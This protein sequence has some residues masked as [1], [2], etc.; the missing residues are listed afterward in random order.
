[1]AGVNSESK[2]PYVSAV[3][4]EQAAATRARVAAAAGRCFAESGWSGT[5]LAQIARQAGV[6]PQ[7]VHL[8]IGPKPALLKAALV[9]AVG[10]GEADDPELEQEV[11]RGMLAPGL[12]TEARARA[13]AAASHAVHQR[14]GR[15]FAVLAQAAQTDEDLATWRQSIG[16][17]RMEVCRALVSAC[18]VPADR[19]T[20][21]RDLVFVLASTSVYYEFDNLGWSA[22]AYDDWLVTA[23]VEALTG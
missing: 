21:V 22:T 19:A 2:R 13:F 10:A 8:S 17:R 15:L 1:M 4:T 23:L 11:F 3:R 12:P 18:G 6:T 14:A 16:A 7:A 5:T 20:E 9:A